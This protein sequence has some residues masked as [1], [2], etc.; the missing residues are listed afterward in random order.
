M[1]LWKF[2]EIFGQ[3]KK[4][5]HLLIIRL[6]TN[7]NRRDSAISAMVYLPVEELHVGMYKDQGN[8]SIVLI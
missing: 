3:K 8:F 5:S 1:K 4:L 6:G 2:C 7:K